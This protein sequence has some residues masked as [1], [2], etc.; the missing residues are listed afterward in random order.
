MKSKTKIEKQLKKKT[1]SV[2][3]ETIILAKKNKSWNGVAGI[4]S[5]PRRLK[6]EINLDEINKE[7]KGN[8]IIIVPG[9]VLSIGEINKKFKVVALAFSE[10]AKEKLNKAGCETSYI[11]NEIKKN[12][13]AKGVK[14]LR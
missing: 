11:I 5:S 12:P 1:N 2:L 14:I 13:D 6:L 10:K 9:K 4:L 8:E 3:V 7:A